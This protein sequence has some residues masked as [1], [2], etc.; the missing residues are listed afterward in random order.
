[1]TEPNDLL[2]PKYNSTLKIIKQIENVKL[3]ECNIKISEDEIEKI[4]EKV[5]I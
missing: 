4:H 3:D 1:M 5:Y 2:K